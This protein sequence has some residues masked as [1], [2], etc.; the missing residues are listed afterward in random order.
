M[1]T[2]SRGGKRVELKCECAGSTLN[3]EPGGSEVGKAV[4][5]GGNM[6]LP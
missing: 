4:V 2:V 5:S 1:D 3:N 6:V